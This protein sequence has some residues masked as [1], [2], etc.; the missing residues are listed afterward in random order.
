MTKNFSVSENTTLKVD[1]FSGSITISEW[2]K[3]EIEFTVTV[4]TTAKKQSE[5][6][7]LLDDVGTDFKQELELVSAKTGCPSQKMKRDCNCSYKIDYQISVPKNIHY[8]LITKYGNIVMENATGNVVVSLTSGK[9]SGNEFS[10]NSKINISHC[11]NLSVKK[12]LGTNN[13]LTCSNGKAIS[14]SESKNLKINTTHSEILIGKVEQ[15]SIENA[16]SDIQIIKA[17]KIQLDKSFYGKFEIGEVK[18]FQ[19]NDKDSWYSKFEINRVT[20]A[21]SFSSLTYGNIAIH[22]AMPSFENIDITACR[23]PIKITLDAAVVSCQLGMEIKGGPLRVDAPKAHPELDF[24]SKDPIRISATV[25][26]KETPKAVIKL[27]TEDCKV[28]INQL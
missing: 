3:N 25:G 2:D 1:N 17:E 9:F 24:W 10:G 6:L 27:K 4:K 7:K 13:E 12:L 14:V 20:G 26:E 23:T 18:H 11:S 5:A 15:L 28:R 21:L 22:N 16:H 19:S 8:D